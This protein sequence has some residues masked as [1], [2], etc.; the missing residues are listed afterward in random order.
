[1]MQSVPPLDEL[2]KMAGMTLPSYLKG[3][4]EQKSETADVKDGK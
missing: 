1:M 4:E 3:A 2:F